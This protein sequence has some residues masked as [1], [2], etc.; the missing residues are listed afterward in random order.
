M[1]LEDLKTSLTDMSPEELRD[2]IRS[3]R[4]DRIIR[5]QTKAQ[6]VAKVKAV[7][8]SKSK[9]ESLLGGMTPEQI[10]ALLKEFE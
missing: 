1:R 5:K 3:I 10:A 8:T 4:A 2:K 9:V 7:A 6:K